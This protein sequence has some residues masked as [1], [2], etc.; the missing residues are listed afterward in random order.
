MQEQVVVNKERD[1]K[2]YASWGHTFLPNNIREFSLKFLFNLLKLNGAI[3]HFSEEVD[4][5][6]TFCSL[7]GRRPPPK[8]TLEHFFQGCQTNI[9]LFSTYFIEF[10]QRWPI[11]FENSFM[12]RD[13]PDN[14]LEF[15]IFIIDIEI[16]LVNFYLCSTVHWLNCVLGNG[17]WGRRS[18][19]RHHWWP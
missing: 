8:E 19:P 16:L 18:G 9:D 13:S 15:Q 7:A 11:N 14:L 5:S 3:S 1:S 4:P 12:L 17:H 10:F 6:F 2:F